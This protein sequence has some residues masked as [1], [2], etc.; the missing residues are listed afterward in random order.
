MAAPLTKCNCVSVCATY[1]TRR[2]FS[3]SQYHS[4]KTT[5]HVES[6][7]PEHVETDWIG[8]ADKVS[9]IRQMKLFIPPD[10]SS[11]ERDYRLK[12]EVV[13]KWHHEFWTAHNKRF[14]TLKE[15]YIQEKLAEKGEAA[16]DI[17]KV[18]PEELSVFYKKFLDDNYPTHIQYNKDW[19]KKNISLLWPA[20]K[21]NFYRLFAR[22]KESAKNKR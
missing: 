14:F 20:L 2:K 19:Y 5:V 17:N 1:I 22:R 15:K 10:E 4:K 3:L 8:P 12:R 18:T 16:D 6:L 21:V 11:L 7:P 13:Q 9:N